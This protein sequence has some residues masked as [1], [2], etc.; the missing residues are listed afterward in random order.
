MK[1]YVVAVVLSLAGNSALAADNGVASGDDWAG[2]YAGVTVGYGWGDQVQNDSSGDSGKHDLQGFAGGATLG[3]N[4]DLQGFIIGLEADASYS[5]IDGS[6]DSVPLEWDCAVGGGCKTTV[7]WFG[8]ARVKLGLP[9]GSVLPYV[10]GGVAIGG[11]QSNIIDD[12][13]FDLDEIGFGWTIGGGVEAAIYD[14]LTLKAEVLYVDFG[15][16]SQESSPAGF[17]VDT[18]FTVARLGL[19]WRF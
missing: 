9:I 2:P 4:M 6:F 3:Y 14:D 11:L 8:T 17:Q 5:G 19:N 7:D 12:P 10:T 15:K 1:K 13:I 16:A 18:N